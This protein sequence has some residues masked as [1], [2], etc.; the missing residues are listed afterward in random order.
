[1]WRLGVHPVTVL[2]VDFDICAEINCVHVVQGKD[3]IMYIN[4]NIP[5]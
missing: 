1:M 4:S 3:V 2:E 5:I